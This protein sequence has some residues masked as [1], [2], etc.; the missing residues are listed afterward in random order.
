MMLFLPNGPWQKRGSSSLALK[1]LSVHSPNP[2]LISCVLDYFLCPKEQVFLIL[3]KPIS[4]MFL[5]L[6]FGLF[7]F[8]FWFWFSL[9]FSVLSNQFLLL[10]FT[11]LSLRSFQFSINLV[12]VDFL[13]V[14][15]LGQGS[16]LCTW[17]S[18][19]FRT[20]YLKDYP[21]CLQPF[22]HHC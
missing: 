10:I 16:L 5:S 15:V 1:S 21:F 20:I 6:L 8:W 3:I 9:A 4:L 11:N 2:P 18:N 19:C 17:I 14:P 13:C 12:Y 7:L 22:G